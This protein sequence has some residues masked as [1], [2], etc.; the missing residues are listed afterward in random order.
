MP[1]AKKPNIVYI[2]LDNVGW[3]NFGVYGGA[4]PTPRIDRCAAELAG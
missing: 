1:T 3:G 2:L 4:I